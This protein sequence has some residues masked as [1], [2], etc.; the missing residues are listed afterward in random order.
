MFNERA[1]TLCSAALRQLKRG[2]THSSPQTY[3]RPLT[4]LRKRLRPRQ[5]RKKKKENPELW[6]CARL[7]KWRPNWC[8]NRS[9]TADQSS[10]GL[11]NLIM[12]CFSTRSTVWALLF[13]S[14]FLFA[15]TRSKVWVKAEPIINVSF[16][17][18][19]QANAL[20]AA[21]HQLWSNWKRC[22]AWALQCSTSA[23]SN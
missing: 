10:A 6:T 15:L 3:S 8:S 21:K 4:K 16:V 5:R 1:S 11:M 23:N 9:A 14:F 12:S 18:Q 13:Y 17:K 7:D 2:A 22:I 20:K 19:M